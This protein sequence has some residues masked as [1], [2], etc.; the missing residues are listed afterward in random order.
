MKQ[1]VGRIYWEA[2]KTKVST[3]PQHL[4]GAA[5]IDRLM[6]SGTSLGRVSEP[7]AKYIES[8]LSSVL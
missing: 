8:R 3:R 5:I 6:G 4:L 1:Q 2:E 7:G